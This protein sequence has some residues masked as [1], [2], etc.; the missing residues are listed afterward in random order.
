MYSFH[1][2]IEY[3]VHARHHS[4]S[5]DT[6]E[7]HKNTCP[8]E[9]DILV[10]KSRQYS[11]SKIYSLSSDRGTCR[12]GIGHADVEMGLQLERSDITEEGTFQ[13]R[14]KAAC[15]HQEKPKVSS[16]AKL[17]IFVLQPLP[18]RTPLSVRPSHS[19]PSLPSVSMAGKPSKTE[20]QSPY[21]PF[22]RPLGLINN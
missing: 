14:H 3:L 16:P 18:E 17:R 7:K 19:L 8:F 10:R 5:Q 11:L 15:N 12:E 1:K 20:S 4:G 21:R 22:F 6:A 13:H 2:Y 9:A